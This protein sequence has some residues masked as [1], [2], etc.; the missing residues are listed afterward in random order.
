MQKEIINRVAKS[1]LITIDL[2][3]FY[4]EGKRVVLDISEWLVDGIFLKEVDFRNSLTAHDWSAYQDN[5]VA[6]HCKT[7]AIIPSWAF[8]LVSLELAPFAKKV[9]IGDLTS[10]ETLLFSE[11]ILQLDIE[12]YRNKPVIV[13]GCTSKP[14]PESAYSLICTKLHAVASKIMY[15]E[16]CSFVPLSQKK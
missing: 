9:A 14:I 8:M 10:L 2:E 4:P 7:D 15:G 13:K 1:K 5:F 12:E 16:A 3:D 11:I 6:V